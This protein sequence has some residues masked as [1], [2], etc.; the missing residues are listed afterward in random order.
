MIAALEIADLGFRG[1]TSKGQ[2]SMWVQERNVA[3]SGKGALIVLS[4]CLTIHAPLAIGLPNGS[5]TPFCE[6]ESIYEVLL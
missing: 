2:C 4:Q 3:S 1:E 6:R 5:Q